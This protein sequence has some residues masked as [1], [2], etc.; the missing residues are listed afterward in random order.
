MGSLSEALASSL[1]LALAIAAS[2]AAIIAVMILLMTRRD[3]SNACFFLAGWFFGLMLVGMIFLHRPALYDSTGEPSLVLGWVRIILGTLIFVTGLVLLVKV[4]RKEEGE[5]NP[6]WAHK[7]DSFR[8]YQALPLGFF[9][10]APNL[11]NA[12]M[13]ITG[14]ASIGSFGLSSFFE[15]GGLILFCLVASIGVLTPPVI[16]LLFREKAELIFGKM[17]LW[18]IRYRD[19]ILTLICIIFGGLFFY[20]GIS[21]VKAF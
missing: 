13:V 21:I 14:S 9:F 6:R 16:F 17:K 19:F 11:K 1:P 3:I 5:T 15:I 10:A 20:Q 7:V 2:P 4:F 12:S 18:L 8:F